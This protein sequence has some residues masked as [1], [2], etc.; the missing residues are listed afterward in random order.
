MELKNGGGVVLA[1]PLQ[2]WKVL[3]T[4]LPTGF[5]F[6]ATPLDRDAGGTLIDP[7]AQGPRVEYYKVCWV[8][9][10]E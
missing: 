5:R 3:P 9:R 6:A 8:P 7:T 2:G 1:V 4:Y 10:G